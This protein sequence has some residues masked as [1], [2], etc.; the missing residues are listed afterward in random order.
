SESRFRDRRTRA[1]GWRDRRILGP[2][3]AITAALVVVVAVAALTS[4]QRF[5]DGGGARSPDQVA[6]A[7]EASTGKAAGSLPTETKVP[8]TKKV[9]YVARDP[10]GSFTIKT[11]NVNALCPETSTT[12]CDDGTST[13]DHP[14]A[15]DQSAS[16]VF[17]S[18]DNKRLIVVNDPSAANSGSI[19]VVPIGSDEPTTTPTPTPTVA[20]ASSSA[21]SVLPSS[22]APP[23]ASPQTNPPKSTSTPSASSTPVP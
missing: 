1:T 13:V 6:L 22:V 20:I 5:G 12:P 10:G 19:S 8:V 21:P 7:S 9:A 4:S 11:R 2:S 3:V 17:G 18:S 15:L 16:T 14:V 23:S